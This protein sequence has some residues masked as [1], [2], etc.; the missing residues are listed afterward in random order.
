VLLVASDELAARA[1]AAA[2]NA[3][4]VREVI[5]PD[6]LRGFEALPRR[7]RPACWTWRPTTRTC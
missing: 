5:G 1:R 2:R 4:G 6:R 3:P 7:T